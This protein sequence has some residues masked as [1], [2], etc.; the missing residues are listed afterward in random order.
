MKRLPV[1]AI[2]MGDP[3]GIGPEIILKAFK[4][5]EIFKQCI[6]IIIG[7][8]TFLKKTAY[9]LN[10]TPL[11]SNI[12]IIDFKNIPERFTIGRPS[13][14]GGKASVKYIKTAVAMAMNKK[15]DAIV[16]APISKE[17]IH[18]AGYK[19]PGHTELIAELTDTKDYAMMLAGKDIRVV[20]VT[21]HTAIRNVSKM[22]NKKK[23]LKVIRLT[24][25]SLK[26]WGFLN[27]RIGVSALNPHG[28]EGGI[29]GD[30]E[31]NK[32]I[33]AA[34]D[35]RAE[36]IDAQGPF[37]ADT[38]FTPSKRLKFDAI[39]VMYHDQGLIPI[40]MSAFGKAV[41]IT[42]GLPFIR[43]SVDHGTAYDI[44]GNNIA[45]P[46]SLIEAVKAAA[47]LSAASKN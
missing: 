32:I 8:K 45:D 7:N 13:R 38:I 14:H 20:L 9:S 23:I 34:N 10:L 19:Y 6:P 5:K 3:A 22:I 29:F 4:K 40:K 47:E 11:P 1:I 16:T 24:N 33:P 15:V 28:G 43:T 41:N 12:S 25:S 35:A 42:L 30:E 2:T 31:I 36:G 37:P 46:S 26:S 17:A 44:V 39:V 21:T 27:P 18:M